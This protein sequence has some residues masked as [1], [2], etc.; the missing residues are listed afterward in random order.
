MQL[1]CMYVPGHIL[2][3]HIAPIGALAL[4]GAIAGRLCLRRI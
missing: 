4:I 1:A 2:L 3:A